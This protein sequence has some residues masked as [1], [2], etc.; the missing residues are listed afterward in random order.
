[1][2]IA[3]V[4]GGHASEHEVSLNS[5]QTAVDALKDSDW[6][7]RL[8]ISK[9]LRVW[10]ID[11]QQ[12]SPSDALK[13]LK[14]SAEVCLLMLHGPF[15]EDGQIQ[16]VLETIEL[17]YTGSG[18]RASVLANDKLASNLIF[19][20]AGLKVPDFIYFHRDDAQAKQAEIEKLDYPLVIKPVLG[21]SSVDIAIAKNW[22]EVKKC[23]KTEGFSEFLAQKFIYGTEVTCGVIDTGGQPQA[24]DL[25]EIVPPKGSFFDYDAKYTAGASQEILPARVS[26]EATK[27]VQAA[28]VTAH[29]VLGCMGITRSDFII[30]GDGAWI[31]EINTA[32]G[33]TDISLVPQ[34]LKAA[35]R[36]LGETFQELC[37]QGITRA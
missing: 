30:N 18:M 9:N 26:D 17:P 19:E 28:A 7:S 13:K 25:I 27:E 4:M 24:L 31:L 29:A 33:M 32:P 37:Q 16:A 21:G 11:G 12:F 36:N 5:G 22:P 6:V 23:L 15:G 10:E 3:V 20:H 35:G 14:H 34:E 8:V 1:M 2:N